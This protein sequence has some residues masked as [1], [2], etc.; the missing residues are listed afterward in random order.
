MT[1]MR[2]SGTPSC[3]PRAQERTGY[4]VVLDLSWNPHKP[5]SSGFTDDTYETMWYP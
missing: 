3:A 5:I 1:L 4:I 2:Q